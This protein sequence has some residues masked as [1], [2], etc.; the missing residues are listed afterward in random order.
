MY[1]LL[2]GRY[3]DTYIDLQL[4]TL[5]YMYIIHPNLTYRA[6]ISVYNY[7]LHE[8]RSIFGEKQLLH[9]SKL[10]QVRSSSRHLTI[11]LT[12]YLQFMNL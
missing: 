9:I 8:P 6:T 1:L 10:C 11:T 7:N 2:H 4:C 5:G 3:I 12:H